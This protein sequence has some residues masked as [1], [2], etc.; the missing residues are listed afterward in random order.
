M[1]LCF[2][3]QYA[4]PSFPGVYVVFKIS[5]LYERLVA[6]VTALK[7][8]VRPE[9]QYGQYASES[10]V[11]EAGN[12]CAICQVRAY[13]PLR[14]FPAWTLFNRSRCSSRSSYSARTCF[15]R[16]A[17]QSGL[18]GNARAPCVVRLQNQLAWRLSGMGARPCCR[19]CFDVAEQ[20]LSLLCKNVRQCGKGEQGKGGDRRLRRAVVCHGRRQLPW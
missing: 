10:E 14:T 11:A 7:L 19:S 3:A 6:M 9:G 12:Q 2:A 15:V 8:I 20:P 1:M 5:M 17:L 18:S 13:A 16:R 4:R